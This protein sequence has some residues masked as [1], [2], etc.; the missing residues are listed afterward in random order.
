MPVMIPM[1]RHLT[2][3]VLVAAVPLIGG[4]FLGTTK[5]RADQMGIQ[6][7]GPSG[8]YTF[9]NANCEGSKSDP[10]GVIFRGKHAGP[11]NVSTYVT[12]EAGWGWT[13]NDGAQG[14]LVHQADGSYQCRA[15][16]ASNAQHSVYGLNSRFHVR[17]WYV[18]GSAGGG[19]VK[20]VGT[21]HHE[22][23]IT[24]SPF[25]HC[26]G[27]TGV[28][29]HAVD[30]GGVN[31]A[32]SSGFD[33]GR[34]ELRGW[35]GRRHAWES[36]NWGN[37]AEFEQC[38]GDMAGS[39]GYGVIIWIN[40]S[41]HP[42]TQAATSLHWTG[43]RLNGKLTTEEA[44][45]EYWFSYGLQSSE[46]ASGYL[47]KTPIRSISRAAVINVGEALQG[48]A[49]NST[50]YARMFARN[51]DGELE[52]GPEVKYTTC[53]PESNDDAT[54][55]VP[56]L[57][58]KS[59]TQ[60][61]FYRTPSGGLGHDWSEPGNP[62]WGVETLGGAIAA[63]SWPHAVADPNGTV[64]V[65]YRTPSGGLGHDWSEPGNPV[66]GVET[67]GGSLAEGAEPHAV[68]T[69]AGELNVFY[70]TPSGGLGHDWSEPGNPV[71]GVE[72]LGGSL[73]SEPVAMA[74][75]DVVHVF[76]RTPGGGLGHDWH[77]PWNTVWGVETLGG[78]LASMPHAVVTPAGELNVF[79]RTPSGG[80][81]HDWSEPGNPVWGVETLGGSLASEPHS[82]VMPNNVVHV[83]YRTP[84]GGLGHDWHEPWNTVWG[85]ET[86]GG[87]L[88]SMPHA[89]VTPAGELNVFYRTPSGGLGHDWSE[90]GNPVW[91]VETLGGSLASEP[92]SVVMPNN[93]VHVFYRT[94]GGGLGHDWHEP[95]NTVWGVETL[96]GSLAAKPPAVT[97]GTATAI[98]S[99]SA[100]VEGTVNPENSPTTYYFEYGP[101]TS[102]GSK[103]PDTT[104]SVGFEGSKVPVSQTL[105]GLAEAATY[106]YRLVGTSAEGTTKGTDKSF[107]TAPANT[108]SR[109]SS[110][111]LT[112]PF[113]GSSSS[114]SA[115]S[116]NWTALGWANGSP[117][118]GEDGTS[119]WHPVA[120]YPAIHGAYFASSLVDSGY[121]LGTVVTMAVDPG[122]EGSNPGRYFSLWL[123]RQGSGTSRSGYELR[124]TNVSASKYDT[125]LSRW[126]TGTQTVLASL[127]GYPVANGNSFA[128]VDQGGTVSA[129]INAGAGFTQ[130]LSGADATF[131]SGNSGLEGSGNFTRLTNFKAGGL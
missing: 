119:G 6:D 113:N 76:Y 110:M 46:G 66:W 103:K 22:D 94:P 18:P 111:A 131:S 97:T 77:E 30:K 51:Q 2:L 5:S 130:L 88:A 50:Y 67:L 92:H 69:P 84:G 104:A 114:L 90:P 71:W 127:P 81:G 44:N 42:D 7:N 79:Y 98:S 59:G 40:R 23:W 128:L 78:S 101:T 86:L 17:L 102:Y 63:G 20:T 123:D 100:K 105:I 89:V 54:G 12:D 126:Q 56:V 47:F 115:F 55:P 43:A 45:T 48:L 93:V 96:G 35:L 73:A 108:S 125:T 124:F 80:L 26:R 9:G 107:Q 87:S 116:A 53:G 109:L 41:M 21:P 8:D 11:S 70:R 85:V 39:D 38:D 32:L 49:P 52:E 64:H 24:A 82:V 15:T 74:V 31:Q 10:V 3:I 57:D 61:V 68:F 120:A 75:G 91:G 106:H 14:L 117:A 13:E 4:A 122:R 16:D 36:E 19:E 29:S 25:N 27:A 33:Q 60:H 28:G 58:C 65:F 95:W 83:F 62:V 72:T 99:S 112:E 118:K 121:G 1:S 37:T 129:W 34:H